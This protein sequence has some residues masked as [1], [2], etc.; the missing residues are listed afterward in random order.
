MILEEKIS[1]KYI[2]KSNSVGFKN[3]HTYEI[4][5]IKTK[6]WYE[7]S[8]T[9]DEDLACDVDLFITYGSENSINNNWE[10]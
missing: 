10:F 5:I 8:A 2:G 3:G 9:H 1:A 7:L 4:T 6:R